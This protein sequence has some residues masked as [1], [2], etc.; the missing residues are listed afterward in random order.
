MTSNRTKLILKLSKMK[1][2]GVVNVAGIVTPNL[3]IVLSSL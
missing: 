3:F 1:A 2:I